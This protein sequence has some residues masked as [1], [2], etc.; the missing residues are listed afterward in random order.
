MDPRRGSV[1]R[2]RTAGPGGSAACDGAGDARGRSESPKGGK[3]G[4][5]RPR[6]AASA[7]GLIGGLGGPREPPPDAL[8]A[9][10]AVA[11]DP[12]PI[13]VALARLRPLRA[14]ARRLERD[15][16]ELPQPGEP[17][18]D[19]TARARRRERRE[20]LERPRPMA[21]ARP[22]RPQE[23]PLTGAQIA[24]AGRDLDDRAV[25]PGAVGRPGDRPDE[26][27]GES[28]RPRRGPGDPDDVSGG[29]PAETSP[30]S[31]GAGLVRVDDP[32]RRPPGGRHLARSNI[33]GAQAGGGSRRQGQAP[34]ARSAVAERSGARE[35]R[36]ALERS[37]TLTQAL[38]DEL[39]P[40]TSEQDGPTGRAVVAVPR[41]VVAAAGRL[42]LNRRQRWL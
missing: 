10:R 35:G 27:V 40:R 4:I 22:E 25:D 18:I 19:P 31:R 37:S 29:D 42:L 17:V 12:A 11:A 16:A 34:R 15:E 2:R 26:L 24:G 23:R 9:S 30:G 36:M 21:H 6:E 28:I 14:L 20:L 33:A 1:P 39:V 3:G 8:A 7:A 32:G 13:G 41:G 5:N 38:G